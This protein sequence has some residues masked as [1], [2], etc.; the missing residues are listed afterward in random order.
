MSW[1]HSS[2]A[3]VLG[4]LLALS[5]AAVGTTAAVS[6]Q[7]PDVSPV[8]VGET[9]SV[10]TT[11]E[12]PFRDAPDQWTLSGSTELENAS[13]TVQVSAQGDPVDTQDFTGQSFSYDLESQTGATEV[14][15]EVNGDA[16]AITS[17]NY[18]ELSAE[19]V[20]VA[21]LSRGPNELER[22]TV[23]THRYTEDSREARQAIDAAIE[24]VGG[25]NDKIGQA[26]SSYNTG[27][28]QNAIS[29]ANEA[30]SGAQ[31]SQLVMIAAGVVVVLAL[32]GGGVYYWRQNR[33]Q[34][35][36]LQ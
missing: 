18:E 11:V 23:T 32:V 8:Q 36:K 24:S 19:N 26:I 29:L 1:I 27:N 14:V 6:V 25:E 15:V 13:W 9:V 28:F 31:S 10:E 20:T 22:G 16:P 33:D 4:V 17:Y 21:A 35:H 2:K 7:E 12:E 5:V 34:G 3:I 30:E